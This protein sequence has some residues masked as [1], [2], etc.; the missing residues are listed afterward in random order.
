[1]AIPDNIVAGTSGVL[2]TDH[3]GVLDK[4][5]GPGN[6]AELQGTPDG[7]V[8]WQL[9]WRAERSATTEV[10]GQV[11][12]QS[13]LDGLTAPY[14]RTWVLAAEWLTIL[15]AWLGGSQGQGFPDKYQRE[16]DNVRNNMLPLIR[17]GLAGNVAPQGTVDNQSVR[18]V[19]RL[20]GWT[21]RDTRG[22]W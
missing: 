22:L 1:M 19:P 12:V 11:E 10:F 4:M 7:Q 3:Q 21:L 8:D 18:Q 2:L 14:P 13:Q 17:K 5:G 16:I 20:D 15:Y 6:L 9:L